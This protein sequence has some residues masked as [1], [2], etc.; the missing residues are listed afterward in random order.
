MAFNTIITT[1]VGFHEPE[2]QNPHKS[3]KRETMNV[4]KSPAGSLSTR[5]VHKLFV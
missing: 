3:H 2:K 5:A 1:A 4:S